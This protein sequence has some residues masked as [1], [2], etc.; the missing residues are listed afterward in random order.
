MKIEKLAVYNDTVGASVNNEYPTSENAFRQP[1][2]HMIVG[3]RTAGKSYLCAKLLGQAKKDKTF[4][5]MYLVS[6]SWNSNKGYFSK[7]ITE[8]NVF[9]P[10]G[11]SISQVIAKVEA[12]K[13]EWEAF[14]EKK[15]K[16]LD[17]QQRIKQR[18]FL[19]DDELLHYDFMGW[20]DPPKWKYAKE[21][22]PKSC[23]ILD[24]CLGSPAI[25]QSSG[26]TRI[27]TLN[28]HLAGLKEDHSGRS[29]CGLAVIILSQSYR[30]QS[31][32][33][34]VLR[35]NLSLLTLFKNKQTKQMDAIKEEL[36]NVVDE[37]LFTKAYEYATKVKF[38][39][40]TVDFRPK[41][42]SKTF[43]KNLNEI[44]VFDELTC[45]T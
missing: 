15:R 41:C 17:I 8:D 24:D 38:G 26:L 42:P 10:T 28:R 29:A 43:R 23:L 35:E 6:P 9:E 19:T 4:D 39:N 13:D 14:L 2:L 3:Q 33:S 7:H 37:S 20:L 18:A 21:E 27:A 11:D 22:P 45:Q 31:G 30:M 34:R 16:Y 1:A 32:I 5:V 25:L 36:A 44:I 12:D 40:L